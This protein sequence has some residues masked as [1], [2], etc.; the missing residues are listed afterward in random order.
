M[1]WKAFNGT[2]HNHSTPHP[3]PAPGSPSWKKYLLLGGII[4]GA[5][6]VGLAIFVFVYRRQRKADRKLYSS[7]GSGRG[8]VR[9]GRG[10]EASPLIPHR[11]NGRGKLDRKQSRKLLESGVDNTDNSD[12]LIGACAMGALACAHADPIAS[13]PT[14][15][16]LHAFTDEAD[17]ALGTKIAAGAYGVVYRGEYL[18]APVAIKEVRVVSAMWVVWLQRVVL[19]AASCGA[20]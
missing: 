4:G 3:P 2:S 1:P 19:T 8:H 10:P 6:L 9:F 20:Y 18:G 7:L 14:P 12:L 16:T 15:V 11:L 5:A 17:I 13:M